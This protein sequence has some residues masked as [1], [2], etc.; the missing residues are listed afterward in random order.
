[1]VTIEDFEVPSKPYFRALWGIFYDEKGRK[2]LCHL[3]LCYYSRQC[4][5]TLLLLV[6]FFSYVNSVVAKIALHIFL[7]V[8]RKLDPDC[9]AW[10]GVKDQ[11]DRSEGMIHSD[12]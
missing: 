8:Y 4:N 2:E 3:Y 5:D 1:M 10:K 12:E 11:C 6:Y 7:R 9:N